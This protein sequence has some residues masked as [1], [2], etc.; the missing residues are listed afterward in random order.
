MK[1]YDLKQ[2]RLHRRWSQPRAALHLG[3]SQPYLAMLETGRRRLT[4]ALTRRFVRRYR[5]PATQLLPS[6]NFNPQ[7]LMNAAAVANQLCVLG[8]P[9][10][11]YLASRVPR[12]NPGE[13]LLA[14]LAQDE[15]EPRLVEALPWLLLR[16]WEMDTEWLVADAFRFTLQNHLGFVVSLARRV[17]ESA[18]V[19][20]AARSATLA[21]L[22]A[23]LERARLARESTF[24]AN[25]RTGAEKQLVMQNQSDDAKRWNLLTDWRPEHLPYAG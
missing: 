22:E 16:Y 4:P 3:V 10:F 19:P 1:P 6:G 25:L 20:N 21:N 24:L 2:A 11:A 18:A 8:Y 12:M 14:A 23:I 17:S 7:A 5:L 13:V 15:L 9:G